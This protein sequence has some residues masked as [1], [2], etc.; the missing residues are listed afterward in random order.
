MKGTE[1]MW[2]QHELLDRN[3]LSL[4]CCVSWCPHLTWGLRHTPALRVCCLSPHMLGPS[5]VSPSGWPCE[6]ISD[7]QAFR[8]TDTFWT[9]S[10]IPFVDLCHNSL[11][12]ILCE[13]RYST[14]SSL[15]MHGHYCRSTLHASV[16]SVWKA[17]PTVLKADPL[18]RRRLWSEVLHAV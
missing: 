10:K 11:Q 16:L 14:P 5:S 13:R 1:A 12:Q 7:S 9:A 3:H 2:Q 6:F 15:N 8:D 4:L 17:M 18:S